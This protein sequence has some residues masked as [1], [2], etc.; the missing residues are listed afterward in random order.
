M[1]WT[2]ELNRG[3]NGH[4]LGWCTIRWWR[5]CASTTLRQKHVGNR[6][7][8]DEQNVTDPV[9]RRI[10]LITT[11]GIRYLLNIY[12]W[13][14]QCNWPKYKSSAIQVS[15]DDEVLWTLWSALYWPLTSFQSIWSALYWPLTSFQS[16]CHVREISLTHVEKLHYGIYI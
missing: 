12:E 16:I 1:E 8:N 15:S 11:Y 13:N 5:S 4:S 6:P 3:Y 9:D 7:N 2:T 14:M 10:H